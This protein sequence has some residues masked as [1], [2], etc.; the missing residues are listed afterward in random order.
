MSWSI[1]YSPHPVE[2]AAEDSETFISCPLVTLPGYLG[3]IVSL[4][5]CACLRR[6][7]Y[8]TRNNQEA[9]QDERMARK[10]DI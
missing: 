5:V 8:S 7:I 2:A 6:L 1:L 3:L 10:L 4:V 9:K